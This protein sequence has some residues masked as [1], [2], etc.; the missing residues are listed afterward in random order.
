[1]P[2]EG[3][4]E[5]G[6]TDGSLSTLM[7]E[8]SVCS[9]VERM[10]LA[11][12]AKLGP[13]ETITWWNEASSSPFRLM[14]GDVQIGS[15]VLE[16]LGKRFVMRIVALGRDKP[17]ESVTT[18]GSAESAGGG[19]LG[20]P[21]EAPIGTEPAASIDNAPQMPQ[22]AP[23]PENAS[24]VPAR[25]VADKEVVVDTASSEPMESSV[26]DEEGATSA[27][28]ETVEDVEPGPAREDAVGATETGSALPEISQLA[29]PVES[30]PTSKEMDLDG[31]DH[32]EI[33]LLL[34]QVAGNQ[35]LHWANSLGSEEAQGQWTRQIA[36]HFEY[37]V[38]NYLE[39]FQ[40]GLDDGTLMEDWIDPELVPALDQ[41]ARFH[42]ALC[43]DGHDGNSNAATA[44]VELEAV[45]Y[46]SLSKLCEGYGWFSLTKVIPYQTSFDPAAH[47][48]AGPS[49]PV[50][51][52]SG[53]IIEVM[54][55]GRENNGVSIIQP[56]VIVGL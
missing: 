23:V 52:M 29:E 27:S 15:A 48:G 13:G 3:T 37:L 35:G 18:D 53:T 2:P 20:A 41:L 49:K 45:L 22:D 38:P 46:G 28:Y 24:A 4:T 16:P 7:I 50:P 5:E 32:R 1:M 40:A 17:M 42:S 43:S 31:V 39:L 12:L 55:V 26:S 34:G 8:V 10:T 6:L 11:E 30:R 36:D 47:R 25:D 44:A 21:Q 54:R 56:N 33:L 9:G 19:D 51:G 14:V